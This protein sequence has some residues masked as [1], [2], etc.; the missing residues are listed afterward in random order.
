MNNVSHVHL[1][2]ELYN[3]VVESD[4]MT[5]RG[6]QTI[7]WSAFEEHSDGSS[8]KY[9]YRRWTIYSDY[10]AEASRAAVFELFDLPG[11]GETAPYYRCVFFMNNDE[12]GI[13]RSAGGEL[14][15]ETRL[16]KYSI[17]P[18]TYPERAV[19]K[20]DDVDFGHV[21]REAMDRISIE[22]DTMLKYNH[23]MSDVPSMCMNN[24]CNAVFPVQASLLCTIADIIGAILCIGKAVKDLPKAL[25]ALKEGLSPKQFKAVESLVASGDLHIS[26]DA[27]KEKNF[28]INFLMQK[29]DK[30]EVAKAAANLWLS[31]RYVIL[32]SLMDAE[33]YKNNLYDGI[34]SFNEAT[35]QTFHRTRASERDGEWLFTLNLL[36]HRNFGLVEFKDNW[37]K[38]RA[39]GLQPNTALLWDILPFSFIIDWFIPVS[40]VCEGIDLKTTM[41]SFTF[42]ACCYSIRK[43]CMIDNEWGQLKLTSYRRELIDPPPIFYGEISD[44]S[45]KT[46]CCRAT[47]AIALLIG[48]S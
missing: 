10:S 17:G 29:G 25:N 12:E 26:K 47:D 13:L 43:E 5:Y 15:R 34:V 32:T 41:M 27:G 38:L 2:G 23:Q 1:D 48:F 33:E 20:S 18:L 9:V 45:T 16:Y 42:S 14:D 46:K 21:Y 3:C 22:F 35:N 36:F 24:C 19:S 40:N 4:G 30:K 28:L 7:T 6:L 11:N 44:T 31:Y 8:I 37:V 39:I